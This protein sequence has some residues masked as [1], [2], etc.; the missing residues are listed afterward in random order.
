[1][2]ISLMRV[3]PLA[4]RELN[5]ARVD[6]LAAHFD[7]EQLGILTVSRRDSVFWLIDGQHRKAALDAIGYGDQQAECEV[8]EGLTEADEAEMFLLRNDTLNVTAY[9]KFKVGV[10]AGRAEECAIDAIVRSLGLRVSQGSAIGAVSAVGTLRT[11]YQRDGADCLRRALAILRDAYGDAGFD[12]ASIN[13]IG[14]LVH[15]YDG[16]IKDATAVA[17]LK[18]AMGGVA[19]LT[20]R[21]GQIRLQC[22]W[23]ISQCTA[24][25]AV[26]LINRGAGG[27]KLAA[28]GSADIKAQA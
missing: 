9:A 3:S 11:V 4:Q 2:P 28:W 6:H 24:A 17:K 8:Y 19:G 10:H 21:A 23:P 20:N 7:I 27:K 1:M 15:R 16:D 12:A 18:T 13:G 14:L 25:A 5:K 22:G 26:D